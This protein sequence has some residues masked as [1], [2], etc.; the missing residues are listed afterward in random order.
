MA[1]VDGRHLVRFLEA[2]EVE[3]VLLV[4]LGKQ[5]VGVCAQRV[6]LSLLE[7]FRHAGS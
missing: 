5:A 3:V 7:R 4:E 2:P 1:L 6:D